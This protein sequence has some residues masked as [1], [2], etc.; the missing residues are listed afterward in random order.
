M[1]FIKTSLLAIW[2]IWLTSAAQA[3]LL[4]SDSREV[5]LL[6]SVQ[7]LEDPS[8]QLSLADVQGMS[9]RFRP[10]THNGT[11]L[12]FG[13]TPSA[14]WIR[15]PLQRTATAPENWLLE[16]HY[17]KLNQLDLHPPNAPSIHT[18]SAEPFNSRPYFDRYFVFP[19][20][21][22]TETGHFYIRA[23]SSYALTVPL[24][25]W[26]PETYQQTQ[27]RFYALQFMYYGGLILLAMY[28]LLIF[29]SL[30]D[31]RFLVYCAY[32]V[33]AGVGIFASN[34]YAR[35]LLWPDAPGFDEVSQSAFLS[36]AAFFAVLFARQLLLQP[37]ERTWLTRG[38]WWSQV[39]FLLTCA[40]SLM[41]LVWPGLLRPANQLLMLNSVL[42]GL[43]VSLAGIRALL[44]KRP[45]IRF[46]LSGWLVLWLGVA[47][48]AMRAFGW[49]P[50]NS[51]T[52]Y[53]VQLSTV[54]ETILMALALGDLLRLEHETL[55]I[56]QADAL[57]AKQSLLEMSQSSENNLRQA[58]KERTEQL[59][60]ALRLEKNLREQY[61]RFGSMISH[62][63]RTPLGIIQS[64]ASLMRKEYEH[65]IDQVTR[66]LD[67][68]GSA[69]QRL[70]VMFDKWLHSDAITQ[71]LE[72]LEPNPLEL[73]PWLRTLV[74]T[75]LHLLL[76]HT[77]ALQMNAQED[78]VLADEYHLGVAL[79]NLIDNAAKY[80]PA[81]S[82]ITLQTRLKSGFVGIAVTDQGPGIPLEVQDKVFG[83]FFR[84]APESQVRGVGL[85][86]SIVDRIARAHHGHVE[87]TSSPGHGATFC[88]WLPV[89]DTEKSI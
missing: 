17:A 70:T 27:Q 9:Q 72:V 25:L 38:M 42:M 44:H 51:V 23:T 31:L 46:F 34:G 67:A 55:T 36:L 71:T 16:L 76:N 73:T 85:G 53:A 18:G 83:E 89:A 84:L 13:F 66:R 77:V 35:Q 10:W 41:Q 68:I 28:G 19:L 69:T 52:S 43:L 81:Q 78:C 88:I 61:V 82:A 12:N 14:Y 54:F 24:T 15:V 86:L 60:G 74:Q 56:A 63:F 59:E 58:V 21:V 5:N 30:R 50:S 8:G 3:T 39:I 57:A 49:V 80:S 2:L 26:Q 64:Q 6:Q 22:G 45:G 20:S 11:E 7:F 62:E 33:T 79:T 32:I 87:L 29:L 47:T 75:N 48:A 40:L 4:T 1:K 65:G 37:D